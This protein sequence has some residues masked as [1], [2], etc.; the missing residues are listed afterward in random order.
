MARWRAR[1]RLY[2]SGAPAVEAEAVRRTGG[3]VRCVE[4]QAAGFLVRMRDG[5]SLYFLKRRRG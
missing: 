1:A 3:R 5:T 4:E 2:F